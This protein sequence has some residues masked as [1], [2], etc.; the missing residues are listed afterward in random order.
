MNLYLVIGKKRG[1]RNE[2][3]D[4]KIN[5]QG[6]NMCDGKEERRNEKVRMNESLL[7]MVYKAQ[8]AFR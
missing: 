3:N 1:D 4:E 8:I 5:R 6:K 2:D 7:C